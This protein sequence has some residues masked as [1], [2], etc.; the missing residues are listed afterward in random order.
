M[1]DTQSKIL[2]W[3]I[4][5]VFYDGAKNAKVVV[6]LELEADVCCIPAARSSFAE[7]AALRAC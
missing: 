1:G 5:A 2:L 4:T 3:N 6:F 7:M